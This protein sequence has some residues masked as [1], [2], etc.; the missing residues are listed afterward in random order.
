MGIDKII[1]FLDIT[2][3]ESLVFG[4]D[5]YP[6]LFAIIKRFAILW[7]DYTE[8][9]LKDFMNK[10]DD[11]LTK[12]IYHNNI[13]LVA[14]K[15]S[16]TKISENS[17]YLLNYP[18]SIS[19]LNIDSDEA[20]RLTKQLG[21]IVQSRKAIDDKILELEYPDG[22]IKGEQIVGQDKGW[23]NIF[24]THSINLPPSNALVLTDSH[25]FNNTKRNTLGHYVNIGLENLI[26]LLNVILPESCKVQFHIL[27]LSEKNNKYNPSIIYKKLSEELKRLR[28]YEIL[29]EMVFADK[30]HQIH[31][32]VLYS[33]YY[34]LICDKGFKLFDPDF[35]SIYDD[36]DILLKSIL[37]SPISVKGDG[38]YSLTSKKLKQISNYC[39]TTYYQYLHKI[40]TV[41]IIS[42]DTNITNKI[43][44]RLMHK[45]SLNEN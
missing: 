24:K 38:D 40:N 19:L 43:N 37:N 31:K 35:V 5:D 25:L 22:Y 18:R 23:L 36:N 3:L 42:N 14:K 15:E 34:S 1:I 8:D 13:E 17:E 27:V 44:N 28:N 2:A 29:L 7:I 20:S 41:A 32:R 9:E 6:N 10:P 12:F 26:N 11:P 16:F 45:Q 21:L 4:F 33:N 39:S 30:K